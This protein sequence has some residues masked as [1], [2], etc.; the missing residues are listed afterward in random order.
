M[1]RNL[2]LER[3]DQ[4]VLTESL[5]SVHEQ[6]PFSEI[7]KAKNGYSSQV[8][9]FGLPALIFMHNHIHTYVY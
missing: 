2:H 6:D 7:T 1:A 8:P 4:G 5:F 3:M 9:K